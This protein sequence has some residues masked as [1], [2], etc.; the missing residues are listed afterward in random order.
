ME[1][2]EKIGLK[3]NYSFK[4]IHIPTNWQLS[5]IH[6]KLRYKV[7]PVIEA[8]ETKNLING[9]HVIPHK[10]IDL[11]L[12]CFNWEAN[13][14]KIIE[15]LN[16]YNISSRLTDWGPM[17]EKDYG[18]PQGVVLCYNNLEFNSRLILGFVQLLDE[19]R[20]SDLRRSLDALCPHQWVHYLCIQSGKDNLCQAQF[21]IDDAFV[22]L[23]TVKNRGGQVP[24]ITDKLRTIIESNRK[25]IAQFEEGLDS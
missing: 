18:G 4:E 1:I 7:A 23:R 14:P 21:E 11:R 8:L 12:S 3:I 19:T 2:L 24:G 15:L 22:W 9:F 13:E 5:D 20:D 10:D 16:R 25:Q 6:S 17:P